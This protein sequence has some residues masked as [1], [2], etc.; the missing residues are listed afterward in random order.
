MV[1]GL[2]S[3]MNGQDQHIQETDSRVVERVV[4][5]QEHDEEGKHSRNGSEQ[6]Q[7][8]LEPQRAISRKISEL[9]TIKKIAPA[10]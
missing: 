3:F 4:L 5:K 9:E 10:A 2:T 6:D 1:R 7:H 8:P